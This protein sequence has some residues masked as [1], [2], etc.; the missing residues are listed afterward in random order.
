MSAL[1]LTLPEGT[2]GFVVYCYAFRVGLG[3][4]IMQHIKVLAYASRKLKVQRRTTPIND[5]KLVVVVFAL[6]I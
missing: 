2:K 3:Y 4:I 1:V 6:K 5:L